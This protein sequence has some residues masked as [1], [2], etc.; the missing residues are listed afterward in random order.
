MK[1]PRQYIMQLSKRSKRNHH[2]VDRFSKE[3][4]EKKTLCLEGLLP[5]LKTNIE[6][7]KVS[8][9]KALYEL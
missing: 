3:W 2:M 9:V 6:T 8:R 1:G 5:L 7:C 4:P